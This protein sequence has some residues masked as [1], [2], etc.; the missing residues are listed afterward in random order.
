LARFGRHPGTHDHSMTIA[1]T[2]WVDPQP[3]LRSVEAL[4][5]NVTPGQLAGPGWQSPHRGVQLPVGSDPDAPLQRIYAAAELLPDDGALG[6]WAAGYLLGAK[7]L[8]GRGFSGKA[9]EALPLLLPP[10]LHLSP[11]E[12]ITYWRCALSPADVITVGGL[13]VSS[14]VRTTFD[15]ARRSRSLERA[16]VALD[17]MAR[18]AGVDPASVRAYLEHRSRLHGLPRLRQAL[19]LADP[20][21][22]SVGESRLRVLWVRD[23]G[24]G[25]PQ[26]NPYVIDGDGR[27]VGMPDLL[28]SDC[29]LVGE[30]DGGQHRD[31]VTHTQDNAR[32]EDFE[33]I[34]LVVVRATS[35]DLGPLRHETVARL[36]RGYAR[37]LAAPSGASWAWRPGRLPP[38]PH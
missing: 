25:A 1:R 9:R 31:L 34:G 23:A 4:A 14:P 13:R 18:Q 21:A 8:D 33:G 32:E 7:D 19:A 17:A 2:A 11:R 36:L 15:I 22:R 10:R 26:S 20:R 29:G 37:A 24:L 5:L 12:G 38:M 27:V 30:Y 35:L 28:L 6:G 3:A 16:V